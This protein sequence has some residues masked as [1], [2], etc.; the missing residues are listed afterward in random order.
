MSCY[1]A[2]SK[3]AHAMLPPPAAP[4]GHVHEQQCL[5]FFLTLRQ[6]NGRLIIHRLVSA[7]LPTLPSSSVSLASTRAAGGNFLYQAL[8]FRATY[9]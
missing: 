5:L 6:G 4:G 2:P 8:S 3:Q 1:M 7:P 9:F